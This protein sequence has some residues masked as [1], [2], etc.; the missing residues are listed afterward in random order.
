MNI[1]AIVMA[2]GFSK[3]MGDNKLKLEVKGKEN[4]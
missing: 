1:S 4:V 2:S 3:R